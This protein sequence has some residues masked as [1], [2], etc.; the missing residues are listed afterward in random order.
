MKE[1]T[2]T[3]NN[4]SGEFS[5]IDY[6]VDNMTEKCVI[7]LSLQTSGDVTKHFF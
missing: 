7:V 6:R 2:D 1:N 5:D 3:I 4:A